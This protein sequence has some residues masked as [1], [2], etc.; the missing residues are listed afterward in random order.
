MSARK[1]NDNGPLPASP[2]AQDPDAEYRELDAAE[3]VATRPVRFD[4]GQNA[5]LPESRR[6]RSYGYQG[7]YTKAPW[8]AEK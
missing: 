3:D 2:Q 7:D 4:K 8:F 5:S 1:M 6:A